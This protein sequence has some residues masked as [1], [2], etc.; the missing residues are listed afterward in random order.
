[1]DPNEN[2]LND[3]IEETPTGGDTPAQTETT[4]EAT[5]EGEAAENTEVSAGA[6]AL[7]ALEKKFADMTATEC[8]LGFGDTH[9]DWRAPLAKVAVFAAA[10]E[11]AA[12]ESDEAADAAAKADEAKAMHEP[13]PGKVEKLKKFYSELYPEEE[14]EGEGTE[15]PADPPAGGSDTPAQTDGE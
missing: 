2:N 11:A 15:T 5:G 4:P 1:M 14:G 12:D 10:E 8:I 7:E 9:C 3:P 13:T 6:A